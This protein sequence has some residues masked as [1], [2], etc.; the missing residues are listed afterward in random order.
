MRRCAET[1]ATI[2][3]TDQDETPLSPGARAF[4]LST[5]RV[6]PRDFEPLT[7]EGNM[8]GGFVRSLNFPLWVGIVLLVIAVIAFLMRSIGS[9]R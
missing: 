8:R 4:D 2:Q 1:T 9:R 3:F 7:P 6:D 5:S